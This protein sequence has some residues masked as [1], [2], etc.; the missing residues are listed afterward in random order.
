MLLELAGPGARHG[1]QRALA[2]SV[3]REVLE[4]DF[5]ADARHVDDAA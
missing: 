5:G 1:F 2:A 4:A 3:E